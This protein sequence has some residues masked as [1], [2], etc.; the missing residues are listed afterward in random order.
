METS[1][2]IA[3]AADCTRLINEF[4]WYTDTLDYDKAVALFVPDCIFSRANEVFEGVDGL[5]AVLNRRASDRRTCHIVSNIVVDVV[6][7]G[8]ATAKAHAL[9][10]GH[11]GMI[12]EGE[13]APLGIPDSIVRFEAAFRR[14]DAGWRIAKW[15]IGLNFR[16]PAA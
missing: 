4:S 11:R 16:K 9:V 5:R 13:E 10:F 2:R 14:T 6:D 7:S 12:K 15:H 1:E 8:H 3:I